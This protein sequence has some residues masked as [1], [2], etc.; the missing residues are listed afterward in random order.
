MHAQHMSD[1]Q[2]GPRT[3]IDR[4]GLDLLIGGAADPGGEEHALLGAVLADSFDADAVAD[5]LSAFEEP[6]VLVIGQVRHLLDP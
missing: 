5:R 4:A 3:G 1:P 6:G 2:Q